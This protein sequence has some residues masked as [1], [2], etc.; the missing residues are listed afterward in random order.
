MSSVMPGSVAAK[1]RPSG[2][3]DAVQRCPAG[4]GYGAVNPHPRNHPGE[5]PSYAVQSPR[6]FICPPRAGC[7]STGAR[8]A[9]GFGPY[10]HSSRPIAVGIGNGCTP[11]GRPGRD[12]SAGPSSRSGT[13][14]ERQ[15]FTV[16]RAMPSSA[17]ISLFVP[18]SAHHSTIFAR[19]ARYC[20]VFARRAQ[21]V[22]SARSASDSTSTG[23]RRPGRRASVRPASRRVANRE[24]HLRTVSVLTPKSAATAVFDAP[25]VQARMMRAPLRR[26][27]RYCAVRPARQLST[28][29]SGQHDFDSTRAPRHHKN[30]LH[31]RSRHF[32]CITLGRIQ[33]ESR[34]AK[35]SACLSSLRVVGRYWRLRSSRFRRTVV[36]LVQDAD[37]PVTCHGSWVRNGPCIAHP[38]SKTIQ[39][40]VLT[41]AS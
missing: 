19:S 10:D 39:I 30:S 11:G 2:K 17:A 27:S 37:K 28:F 9:A 33:D 8:Q 3:M 13:N 25:S 15:R 4:A 40:R 21:H 22:N 35:G 36:A 6:Q 29:L 38:R 16:L 23:L 34:T 7:A 1:K 32:W 41:H 12:S 5:G 26:T 24:R 31:T 14:L 20:A 18:P